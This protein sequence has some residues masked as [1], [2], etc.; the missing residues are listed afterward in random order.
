M[1][2][3]GSMT[4]NR[5]TTRLDVPPGLDGVVAVATSVGDVLGQD[6]RFHYRGHDAAEL[7]TT[8]TADAVRDLLL[9]GVLPDPDRP[10][11]PTDRSLPA[12]VA[13]E[14]PGVIAAHGPVGGA[15]DPLRSALSL[16]GGALG[17]RSW[18]DTDAGR[19]AADLHRIVDM[20]PTLTAALHRLGAGLEPI[21]PDPDLDLPTDYL[22]MLTGATPTPDAV[23]ALSAYLILT[24]DHG[25]NAS[26]FAARVVTSTG[27]DPAAALV[28]A[29]AAMSGP[30][31]GGAPSRALDMLDAIGSPDR[32]GAWI[33][34][35]FAAG[36]RLM[37]FGHRVYRT[38]DPRAR[39][40]R[41]IAVELG[42]DLVSLALEVET[43]ALDRLAARSPNRPLRTNVEYWAGVVM[44]TV[45]IERELFTPTFVVARSVGWSAHIIEQAADNRLIR[46]ASL[47]IG[48]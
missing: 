22:R 7:A 40:L 29:V 3:V 35:E 10:H 38:D 28:A 21:D 15:L 8:H 19:L 45:G 4:E 18:L 48:P 1:W 44:A 31:H 5:H 41:S 32:A 12:D 20:M 42:G 46:P 26:T 34:R 13:A 37:G 39:L 24:M 33:D 9:D 47:Y 30:L 2:F 14:L 27:A 25:S 11:R 17:C 36:R 43:T 16:L 6:G 23:A